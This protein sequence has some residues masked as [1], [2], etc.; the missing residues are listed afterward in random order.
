VEA[1]LS[2]HLDPLRAAHAEL[3]WVPPARWHVTLEF[4]GDCG[5]HEFERQL[6]RWAVRARRVEP[7]RMTVVGGGAF[8]KT[9]RARVL[10]AGVD[11][12]VDAWRR[13]ARHEQS[14]HVTLAR[15][16]DL[17]DASGLVDALSSYSGPAWIAHE[18]ALVQSHLR[19]STD[20]G[21][22]YE[23]LETFPLGSS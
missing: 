5:R 19:G 3:R 21:P 18:V 13:L 2:E 8:P 15:T 23:V 16:R 9:W 7:L 11:V 10:W 20:R 12:D 1:H 4:L 17:S 14:A 22:R 6:N